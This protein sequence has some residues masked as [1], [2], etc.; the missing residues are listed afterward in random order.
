MWL[1]IIIIL[2]TLMAVIIVSDIV[3]SKIK[4]THYNIQDSKIKGRLKLV[5]I[6]DFHNSK[7][8]EKIAEMVDNQKPDV[9]VLGGDLFDRVTG[10]KY[11]LSLAKILSKKYKTYFALG[12]H[13]YCVDNLQEVLLTLWSYNVVVLENERDN[14]SFKENNIEFLGVFDG[15]KLC[16]NKDITQLENMKY[17]SDKEK[18]SILL[19]HFPEFFSEYARGEFDLILSGHEHGGIIRIPKANR[20]LIGHNGFF[21]KYCKGMYKSGNC[22]MIVSGGTAYPHYNLIVPRFF[23]NP[24]VVVI[25]L[26]GKV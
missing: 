21:P 20:G 6:S 1:A 3:F 8:V 17:N 9:V 19:A 7:N 16:D 24:E 14:I 18:Y 15:E 12:N 4:I 23:N 13:E 11:G 25:D 5:F 10:T 2:L 22:K 26:E